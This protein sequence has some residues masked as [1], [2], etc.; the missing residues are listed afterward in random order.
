MPDTRTYRI[1]YTGPAPFASAVAQTLRGEG[2]AVSWMPPEEQ[3]GL[4]DT[5]L[6]A[7]TVT[8]IVKGV[9]AVVHAAVAKA[10]EPFGKHG[11]VEIEDNHP[12]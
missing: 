3:R 4:G 12:K 11:A 2:L 10:R 8:Y 7:V 6:D 1:R 5:V 9:D